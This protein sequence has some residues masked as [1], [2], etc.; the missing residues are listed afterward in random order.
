MFIIVGGCDWIFFLFGIIIF[1]CMLEM[2]VRLFNLMNYVYYD[3]IF[4]VN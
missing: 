1:M 3:L 2:L 4:S